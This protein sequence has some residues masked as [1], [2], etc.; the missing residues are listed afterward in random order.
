MT[1]NRTENHHTSTIVRTI[2]EDG[3]VFHVTMT[4]QLVGAMGHDV[5]EAYQASIKIVGRA[6]GGLG[7]R[8]AIS[9]LSVMAAKFRAS[10]IVPEDLA[11]LS[12]DS[13]QSEG[14]A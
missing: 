4:R 12:D 14:S 1:T 2:H 11:A 8:S 7:A 9:R 5:E 13:R 10:T 6:N 3:T